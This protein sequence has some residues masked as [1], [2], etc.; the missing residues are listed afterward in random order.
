VQLRVGATGT[1]SGNRRPERPV[2]IG[3]A[4]TVVATGYGG[5]EELTVVDEPVGDPGVDEVRVD[6][7]AIGTNP[8][9][10]KVYSGE[11]GS[12]PAQLPIRVGREAAGVLS[13][14]GYGAA[15]ASGPLS[16]GDEVMLYPI[17]GAYAAQLLV[18]ASSVVPKP[19][20]LPFEEAAGLLLT[21][22]TAVQA[23]RAVEVGGGDTVLVHGAAGGVGL[24]AVQ[25][26]VNVG[27]RVI[28]TASQ[29]SFDLVRGFGAEPVTYG[30]GLVERVRALAPDGVD[31]AIDTVGTDEAIDTSLALVADRGRIT[32]SAGFRRGSELGLKVLRAI[33]GADSGAEI[34]SAARFELAALAGEGK[35]RVHVAATYPLAQAAEAHRQLSSGHTHGKIILIP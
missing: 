34:R 16:V 28:G 11:I 26:A 9:D 22:A 6:V 31:A 18:P 3:V 2:P 21:G 25:L 24:M 27:A 1:S 32:T 33:P 8:I 35:I 19:P 29:S 20:P 12:D 7:R 14:V 17:D 13:A 5:P 15:G 23:L 10:V 30:D 4:I